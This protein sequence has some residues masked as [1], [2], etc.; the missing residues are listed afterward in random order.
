MVQ[1]RNF[2]VVLPEVR[3]KYGCSDLESTV[4]EAS[5]KITKFTKVLTEEE[6]KNSLKPRPT[7][8]KIEEPIDT[9]IKE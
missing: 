9:P 1:G 4:D 3:E 7:A 6:R 5:L 2:W 8:E